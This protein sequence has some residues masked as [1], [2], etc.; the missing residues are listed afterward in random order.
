MKDIFPSIT[1][2]YTEVIKQS[3]CKNQTTLHLNITLASIHMVTSSLTCILKVRKYFKP[4]FGNIPGQNFL[5]KMTGNPAFTL[6][7]F[8]YAHFYVNKVNNFFILIIVL[9]RIIKTHY[10]ILSRN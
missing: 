6:N 3:F 8:I 4:V 5:I 1:Y 7:D 9:T 2:R 10:H